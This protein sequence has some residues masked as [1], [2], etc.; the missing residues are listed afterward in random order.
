M[1][2]QVISR[3]RERKERKNA[4]QQSVYIRSIAADF[5]KL[6]F[7]IYIAILL[8]CFGIKIIIYGS[9]HKSLSFPISSG[10]ILYTPSWYIDF[11]SYELFNFAYE[12][13]YKY[14]AN[15]KLYTR[16]QKMFKIC[17]ICVCFNQ[18][19]TYIKYIPTSAVSTY[20]RRKIKVKTEQ[21][22]VYNIFFCL[23][24]KPKRHKT[25]SLVLSRT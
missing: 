3:Y 2:R 9:V 18:K 22:N 1:T 21:L 4:R 7:V 10:F 14:T 13:V 20:F 16:F 8:L 23:Y 11:L 25:K 6:Y 24:I 17:I 12:N 5:R 15:T 19:T